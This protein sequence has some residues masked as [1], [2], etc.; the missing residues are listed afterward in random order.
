MIMEELGLKG[1]DRKVALMANLAKEKESF[2]GEDG[3][4]N[5]QILFLSSLIQANL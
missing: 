4:K 1:E 2:I 3:E 5:I